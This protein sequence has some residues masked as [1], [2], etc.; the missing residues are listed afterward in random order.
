MH[1]IGLNVA[2]DCRRYNGKWGKKTKD[3]LQ[4]LND[5]H[6][7]L[8]HLALE[9]FAPTDDDDDDDDDDSNDD[10]S[11]SGGNRSDDGSLDSVKTL[12]DDSART[13]AV[14]LVRT[15]LGC[16]A[17]VNAR[18]ADERA[19]IH[20]AVR[21]SLYNIVQLLLDHHADPTV[22]SKSIGL[23]NNTL[24]QATLR[25]D[26]QMI[27][28]LLDAVD[29]SSTGQ[30]GW[31]SLALAARAGNTEVAETLLAAGAD[32]NAAMANGK[33]AMD[34]ARINNKAAVIALFSQKSVEDSMDALSAADTRRANKARDVDCVSSVAVPVGGVE[35][36]YL[37]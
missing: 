1:T 28:L 5:E 17:D 11:S 24:H 22:G 30:G 27:K 33:S 18:D 20:Q 7:S 32:P 21:A 4:T 13:D 10:D 26:V 2:A 6:M 25:G 35:V 15:L 31:T 34:I 16:K 19:P 14:E 29:V 3:G 37:S 23:K 9:R 8:L 12:L 36:Q